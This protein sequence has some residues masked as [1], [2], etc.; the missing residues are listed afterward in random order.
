LLEQPRLGTGFGD[1]FG[2][3]AAS[4]GNAMAD[5]LDSPPRRRSARLLKPEVAA[6]AG[7]DALGGF[8]ELLERC[9]GVLQL[10]LDSSNDKGSARRKKPPGS[11][12]MWKSTRVNPPSPSKEK[13][14]RHGTALEC[15]RGPN[16]NPARA[17]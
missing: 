10:L 13:R 2:R 15:T 7:S 5:A 6:R 8:D 9:N 4:Q 16:T 17:L 11:P 12:S 1:G 14:N 3:R